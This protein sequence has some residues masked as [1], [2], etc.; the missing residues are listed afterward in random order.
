LRKTQSNRGT[1]KRFRDSA[2]A[3]QRP[4]PSASMPRASQ[5]RARLPKARAPEHL[6]VIPAP[7]VKPVAHRACA[8]RSVRR[9]L[10]CAHSYRG[11]PSY[12]ALTLR[13]PSRRGLGAA[14]HLLVS[15]LRGAHP[16]ITRARHRRTPLAPPPPCRASTRSPGRATVQAPPLGPTGVGTGA[17]CPGCAAPSPERKLQ[18]PPPAAPPR[19]LAAGHPAPNQRTNQARVSP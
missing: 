3:R 9:L 13:C 4:P 5:G 19:T 12:V 6:E 17:Y 14:L 16:S 2:P 15:Y 18:R 7:R 8:R 10:L 1:L 11:S